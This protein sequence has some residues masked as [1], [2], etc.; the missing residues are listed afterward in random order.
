MKSV[1]VWSAVYHM[2]VNIRDDLRV[3][4][5]NTEKTDSEHR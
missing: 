5:G 3:V 1:K 2:A 4:C